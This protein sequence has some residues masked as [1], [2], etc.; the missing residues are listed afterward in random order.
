MSIPSLVVPS[1]SAPATRLRG[2]A[3]RSPPV[4]ILLKL[5]ALGVVAASLAFFAYL[6]VSW[7]WFAVLILVPDL[8]AIGYMG[9]SRLGSWFYD[10]AHTY[11]G[12]AILGVIGYLVHEPMT[13]AIATVWFS[14]IGVDQLIGYGLKFANDPKDTH[15]SRVGAS[16][17]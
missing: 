13:M 3:D 15:L 4:A 7:W 2:A 17:A 9:G 12:P 5:E 6:G 11:V 8:S 14:H 16:R 1:G 10:L